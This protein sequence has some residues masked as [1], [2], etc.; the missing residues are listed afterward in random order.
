NLGRFRHPRFD[1][2]FEAMQALPDGPQRLALLREAQRIVVAYMPQKYNVH[3]IVTDLTQ[4]WLIGYRRPL[5]GT[6]F[7]SYVD[8]DTTRQQPH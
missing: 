2:I 7:W 6:Q 1:A 5:F 4:P 8:I 3:R